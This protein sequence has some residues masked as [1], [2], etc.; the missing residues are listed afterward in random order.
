MKRRNFI[1]STTSCFA[2]TGFGIG[3]ASGASQK[4]FLGRVKIASKGKKSLKVLYPKGSL[5][6]LTPIIEEFQNLTGIKIYL[7]E[8][9]LDKIS[10]EVLVLNNFSKSNIDIALPATFSIPDL[11]EAKAIE[12]LDPFLKKYETPQCFETSLY[13]SGDYY[14]NSLYGYQADGDTYLMFYRKD[15]LNSTTLKKEYENKYSKNLKLPQTWEELDQQIKFFHRPEK[16]IFGGC[17]FRNLNYIGWEYWMRLHGKGLFPVD[18]EM[19]PTFV[20]DSG[21]NALE[22]LIKTSKYLDPASKEDGLFAN[23]KRFSKGKNFCNIGWGGTQKF[24]NKENS[25]IRD[26]LIF[27]SPPGGKDFDTSFFNWGWNFVVLNSS[28]NKELSYLFCKFAS[29][30]KISTRSVGMVDGY[31]DPHRKEHYKDPKIINAYGKE[32]LKVHEKSLKN[33]IPDFYLQGQ[34]EYLAALKKAVY[35]ANSGRLKPIKALTLAKDKWNKITDKYGRGNQIS[36]WKFLKSQYPKN[37]LAI[38]K[39]KK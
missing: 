31:F 24:L 34:G 5:A 29:S 36:Q 13:R 7:Q 21:I 32:F 23:F 20:S 14:K 3:I 15:L 22:D 35:F 2:L 12:N 18:D 19:N 39:T 11:V 4:E 26:N 16:Q 9:S 27:S 37:F 28:E 8:G 25:K 30:A 38:M 33:S 6:N 10:S 1:K 17:L